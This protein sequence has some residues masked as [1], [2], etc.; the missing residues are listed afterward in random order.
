MEGKEGRDGWIDRDRIG[1][2]EGKKRIYE[3]EKESRLPGDPA[4]CF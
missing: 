3:R 2:I 4:N 1:E